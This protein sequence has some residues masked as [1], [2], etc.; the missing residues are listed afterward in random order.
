[1]K[2]KNAHFF[3]K[4]GY[5]G[6]AVLAIRHGGNEYDIDLCPAARRA[7]G[8]SLLDPTTAEPDAPEGEG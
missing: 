3:V 2:L 8:L 1:M 4:H 6:E 5:A 7:L